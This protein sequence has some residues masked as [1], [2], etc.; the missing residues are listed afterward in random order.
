[1]FYDC[2]TFNG[3]SGSPVVK[4]VDGKLRVMA[5][6]RGILQGTYYNLATVFSD[7]FSHVHSDDKKGVITSYHYTIALQYVIAILYF[8]LKSSNK[9]HTNFPDKSNFKKP[10]FSL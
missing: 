9:I 4:V 8:M 5:I 7:V 6:H 2:R 10:A 3:S 1:M